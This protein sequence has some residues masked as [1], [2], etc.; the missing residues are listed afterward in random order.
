MSSANGRTF[1]QVRSA[2]L[3]LVVASAGLALTV[4]GCQVRPLYSAG[5]AV[6]YSSSTGEATRLSSI[7]IKSVNNRPAQIV[8]N[9]M[10]FLF[11]GGAQPQAQTRYTL[12]LNVTS[13]TASAAF[14]QVAEEDEP[15]AG[16]VTMRGVYD[17]IDNET[18]EVIRRGSR[19]VVASYDVSRQQFAALRAERDAQERA[20]RELAELLRLSIAQ[21]LSQP[22]GFERKSSVTAPLAEVTPR[23]GDQTD[24]PLAD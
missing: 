19:Q 24:G 15:T 8:R 4:A 17:L 20:G 10:I 16:T 6:V 9:Q 13:E 12:T 3:A 21:D 11:N 22:A 23:P 7:S 1:P 2:R 14:V 18:G 5:G